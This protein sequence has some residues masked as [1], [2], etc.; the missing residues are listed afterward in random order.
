MVILPSGAAFDIL[1]RR[2]RRRRDGRAE[3]AWSGHSG[4]AMNGNDSGRD[5]WWSRGRWL[6]KWRA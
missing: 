2:L 1:P 3:W 6:S 5:I 4:S